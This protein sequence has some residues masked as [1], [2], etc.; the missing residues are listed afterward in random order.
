VEQNFEPEHACEQYLL[1]ELSEQEQTQLEEAYFADDALF[2]RFLAVREDLID[3]YARGDLAG[4]KRERF[5][6]HFMS[7]LPRLQRVDDAKAFISAVTATSKTNATTSVNVLDQTPT[8]WWRQAIAKTFTARPLVLRGALATLLIVILAGAWVLFSRFQQDKAQRQTLESEQARLKQREEE[9]APTAVQ[10]VNQHIPPTNP[11]AS[12]SPDGSSQPTTGNKQRDQLVPAQVAFLF[13]SPFTP[14]DTAGSNLLLLRSNTSAARLRLGFK[15]D[16][17]KRYDVVLRTLDG[18]QVLDR[19]ALKLD[20]NKAGKSVTLTLDPSIFHRQDY[21]ITL[22][23]LTAD[24]KLE[25][26]GEYYFRVE[27]TAP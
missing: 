16:G 9:R 22:S 21:I 5:E 3:A 6:Q 2:E 1:G 10:P 26:I 4:E 17:Y 14:R 12:P 13:L 15:A 27:R 23:G 7:S 20:S 25:A 8:N 18:E 19:R 11:T 24:G